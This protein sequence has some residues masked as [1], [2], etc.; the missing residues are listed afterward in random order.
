MSRLYLRF[1]LALL[2]S[3]VAFAAITAVL[4]HTV[5]A[6]VERGAPGHAPQALPALIATLVVLALGVGL[7][8]LP[9]VRQLTRRLERLQ[10]GV[11]SLGSGDLASRVAV[12][13]EDEVAQLATSFNHAAARIQV[14]VGANRA[15]LANVSHEL[16]TP[17]ARIRLTVEL[18]KG[19][20]DPRRKAELE[21]DIAEL[22]ELIDELLLSS[23][24]DA[25]SEL[26]RAEDVDLLALAAEECARFG[27]VDLSG[28]PAMVHGDPRLLRRLLRNLLENAG[29]HGLPPIRVTLGR[30]ADLV[31]LTVADAGPIIPAEQRERLFEPFFRRAAALDSRGTGLGLSLVRQIARRHGGD[32]LCT[33]TEAGLNGFVATLPSAE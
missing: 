23:R 17:L 15:L 25:V 18:M 6:F 27:Q 20:A 13:G 26:E 11:E 4:W 21:Q 2:G 10:A 7:G 14:L 5:T 16:R 30:D 29:R 32:A 31:T 9:I 22:D 28:D 3:L 24:L 33:Q 8:A 1:Y 19:S 12:E